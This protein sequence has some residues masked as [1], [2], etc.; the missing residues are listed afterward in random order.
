MIPLIRSLA[1]LMALT[2]SRGNLNRSV[3]N[4]EVNDIPEGSLKRKRFINYKN[5]ELIELPN[6]PNQRRR[7]WIKSKVDISRF[8]DE[9]DYNNQ[10]QPSY[11][12]TLIESQ[13]K[14][15]Q[16]NAA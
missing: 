8:F 13:S 14:Y 7:K 1:E 5:K 11:D 9:L 6:L 4:N 10:I 3:V 12:L 2:E 16:H 15:D